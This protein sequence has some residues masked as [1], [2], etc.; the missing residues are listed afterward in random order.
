[1]GL[2]S[3]GVQCILH[4]KRRGVDFSRTAT[5]GRQGLHLT[6][7]EFQ[8]ALAR[9]GFGA[10]RAT[11]ERIFSADAGFAGELF[12]SLGASALDSFDNSAYEGA[13]ALHDMNVPLPDRFKDTYSAVI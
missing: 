7:D 4:A 10:E 3:N 6:R 5:I 2:D 11:T 12:R 13:T 8:H 1:M 9:C